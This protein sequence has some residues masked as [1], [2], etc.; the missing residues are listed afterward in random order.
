MYPSSSWPPAGC[1]SPS[2]GLIAPTAAT[3]HSTMYPSAARAASAHPLAAGH[4]TM[5]PS[6]AGSAARYPPSSRYLTMYPSGVTA[7]SSAR[8]RARARP[9]AFSAP[10]GLVGLLL[11]LLPLGSTRQPHQR[12][13]GATPIPADSPAHP[14]LPEGPSL[15]VLH[16]VTRIPI[17]A[18]TRIR[19]QQA[20]RRVRGGP[21]LSPRYGLHFSPLQRADEGLVLLSGGLRGLLQNLRGDLLHQKPREET[22]AVP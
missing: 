19:R 16:Q 17:R 15:L 18:G 9:G 7:P 22:V 11:I 13:Q 20:L 21:R 8:S 5:Y 2:G 6:A 10:R 3:W 12:R 4:L 1:P 14:V